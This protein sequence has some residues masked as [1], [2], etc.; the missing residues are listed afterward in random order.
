MKRAIEI[1]KVDF[2][3]APDG[4]RRSARRQR[5]LFQ[6]GRSQLDGYGRK[7]YHQTGRAVDVYAYVGSKASWDEAALT[8][9]SDAVF[10]AA[11]ELGVDV[12]WGGHWKSFRDM[13]HFQLA[14]SY[15]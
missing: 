15:Q 6:K 1:T 10:Q 3:I 5:E 4:G 9:I 11:S 14:R 7:S 8:A 13:P 2:G 12:E